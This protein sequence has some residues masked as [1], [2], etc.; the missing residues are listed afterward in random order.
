MVSHVEEIVVV[1]GLDG[2]CI[3]CLALWS[4]EAVYNHGAGGASSAGRSGAW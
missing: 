2:A 1:E 4:S 3:G